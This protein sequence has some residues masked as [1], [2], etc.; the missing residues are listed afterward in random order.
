MIIA[1]L[2]SALANLAAGAGIED[3]ISWVG[4][5]PCI[6]VDRYEP[7]GDP[8]RD[9]AV[10]AARMAC[11]TGTPVSRAEA[12]ALLGT[13]RFAFE[14]DLDADKVLVAARPSS[15]GSG[16]S[17]GA[18]NADLDEISSGLYATRFRLAHLDEAMLTFYL[19]PFLQSDASLGEFQTQSWRGPNA[20][21][22]SIITPD[23][24]GQIEETTLY[25]EALGETRRLVIY[26]P[27][28]HDP[29]RMDYP[30]LIVAD[31]GKVHYYGRQIDAWI[32]QGRIAPVVMIGL[33]SGREGIVEDTEDGVDYRNADY[34]PDF[35]EPRERFDRH[36]TFAADEVLAFARERYGV[37]HDRTKIAVNGRSSGGGFA[38]HAGLRRPDVFG[39]AL[40][41]SPGATVPGDPPPA[42]G[43]SAHFLIVAGRYETSFMASAR[44]AQAA[45]DALGYEVE[46][47]ELSAGHTMEITEVTLA[48]TLARLFPGDAVDTAAD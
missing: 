21:L 23:A 13:N 6:R 41:H 31:G 2:V 25:S 44:R 11:R 4:Q 9:A 43:A 14:V 37:S 36:L 38:Y 10:T 12:E 8:L 17:F 30:A 16:R 3:E 19:P 1:T 33:V 29:A 28:G 34:L 20:P 15:G 35:L 18:L 22:M 7:T 45:L 26:T 32:S 27:P 40:V 39:H 5:P 42:S 48:P 47:T 24:D 46:L